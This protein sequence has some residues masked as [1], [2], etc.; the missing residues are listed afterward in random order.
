MKF[1]L[2]ISVLA[3][4]FSKRAPKTERVIAIREHAQDLVCP[5]VVPGCIVH[6]ANVALHVHRLIK[7]VQGILLV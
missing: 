6:F 7:K 3:T 5:R 4:R 1:N 2:L